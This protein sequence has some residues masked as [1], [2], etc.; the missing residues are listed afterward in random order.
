MSSDPRLGDA[1]Q[2]PKNTRPQGVDPEC[3]ASAPPITTPP[4]QYRQV[5]QRRKREEL[6]PWRGE[7]RAPEVGH[8][9]ATA[10][11]VKPDIGTM[12]AAGPSSTHVRRNTP[13]ASPPSRR[14]STSAQGSP[15]PPE[16]NK[17]PWIAPGRRPTMVAAPNPRRLTSPARPASSPPRLYGP[18]PVHS[19]PTPSSVDSTL[20]RMPRAPRETQNEFGRCVDSLQRLSGVRAVIVVANDTSTSSSSSN[21]TIEEERSLSSFSG[22]SVEDWEAQQ[23]EEEDFYDLD[24]NWEE[25]PDTTGATAPS[26]T[27]RSTEPR[28]AWREMDEEP[29][30][31]FGERLTPSRLQTRGRSPTLL[32]QMAATQSVR[33]ANISATARSPSPRRPGPGTPSRSGRRPTPSSADGRRSNTLRE[34][35]EQQQR[36]SRRSATVTTPSYRGRF[37]DGMVPVIVIPPGE[38]S[39]AETAAR[40]AP[41]PYRTTSGGRRTSET[42]S[43]G[44]GRRPSTSSATQARSTRTSSR[45]QNDADGGR[46][47][48]EPT[49]SSVSRATAAGRSSR[50][51]PRT[52]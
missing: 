52:L 24:G 34:M 39:L 49:G 35:A 5:E 48:E 27:G 31:G 11:D 38:R 2:K 44:S 8:F 13:P 14:S 46:Q 10:A 50:G 40:I 36:R 6:S 33:I 26:R 1:D 16:D 15:E 32:Q 9:Q 20:L 23:E 45:A 25:E 3:Y 17:V 51:T 4:R 42:E 19:R 30:Y 7:P 41:R 29:E 28:R 43:P 37:G 12:A 47:S 21:S 18:A 22:M